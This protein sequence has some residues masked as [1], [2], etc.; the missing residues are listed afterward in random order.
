MLIKNTIIYSTNSGR[1]K[2]TADELIHS[3]LKIKK[4]LLNSVDNYPNIKQP[5]VSYFPSESDGNLREDQMSKIVKLYDSLL[6]QKKALNKTIRVGVYNFLYDKYKTAFQGMDDIEIVKI[7]SS[8]L[9][10][11]SENVDLYISTIDSS[12]TESLDLLQYNKTFGIF[13]VTDEDMKNYIDAD[14]KEVRIKLL[15]DIHFKSLTEGRFVIIGTAPYYTV[16]SKDW[17]AEPPKFFVGFPVWKIK[18]KN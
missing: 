15:Q 17:V 16:L 9:D 10:K 2:F 11:N 8:P 5:Q 1:K 6:N 13:D 18:R 12:F 14:S 3:S 4:L 7:T